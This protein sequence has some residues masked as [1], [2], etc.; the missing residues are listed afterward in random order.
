MSFGFRVYRRNPLLPGNER[1]ATY[2][3]LVSGS[4]YQWPR[5]ARDAAARV[6]AD[7]SYDTVGPADGSAFLIDVFQE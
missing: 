6:V 3:E 5:Q 7:Q 1:S 2:N 4:G